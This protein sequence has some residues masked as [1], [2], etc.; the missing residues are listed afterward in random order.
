MMYFLK[1]PSVF[2]DV[3]GFRIILVASYVSRNFRYVASYL[4]YCIRTVVFDFTYGPDTSLVDRRFS[5][6]PHEQVVYPFL[7]CFEI[8]C[9]S[10]DE[11]IVLSD[12]SFNNLRNFGVLYCEHKKIYIDKIICFCCL[13]KATD[14]I[15]CKS[16]PWEN[17]P[18]FEVGPSTPIVISK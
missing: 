13:P 15:V 7:K 5:S 17:K 12:T 3:V 11:K 14:T 9:E 4:A 16:F 1:I 2:Y 18:P 10:K 8:T 6:I